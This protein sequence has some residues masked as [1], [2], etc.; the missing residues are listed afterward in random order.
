MNMTRLFSRV[1]LSVA[2]VSGL[3]ACAQESSPYGPNPYYS[4]QQPQPQTDSGTLKMT[5]AEPAL[6]NSPGYHDGA[7]GYTSPNGMDR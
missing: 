7:T 6:P 3:A 1:M 4:S 5:G 2:L